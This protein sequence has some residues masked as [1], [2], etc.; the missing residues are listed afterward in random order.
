M[1]AL[2]FDNSPLSHFARAGELPTLE[3]ITDGRR[4]CVVQEVIAELERGVRSYPALADV[5]ESQ[6]LERVQVA[7]PDSESPAEIQL[8]AIYAARLVVGERHLGEAA[9]LAWAESN[10][11]IAVID[12]RAA[13][14]HGR[15]RGVAVSGSLNLIAEAC[16]SG[17]LSDEAACQLV[18]SLRTVH[19]Y[20]PCDGASF[21]DWAR[22]E[23]LI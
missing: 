16:R 2:V 6:W 14:R 13:T 3:A 9:T 8:F 5:L 10:D 7:G 1:R 4:R 19:A 12:E 17:Q 21:L 23:G 18:D 22:R 11:A 20:L 15:Q